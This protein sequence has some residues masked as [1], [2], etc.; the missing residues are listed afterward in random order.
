MRLEFRG[1]GF[2]VQISGQGSGLKVWGLLVSGCGACVKVGGCGLGV[3]GFDFKVWG[4][5]FKDWG[6]LRDV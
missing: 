4:L 6:L 2:R 1:A 3:E 5:G